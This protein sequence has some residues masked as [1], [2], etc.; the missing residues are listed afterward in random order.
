MIKINATDKTFS[1]AQFRENKG[2]VL[3]VINHHG[4]PTDLADSKGIFCFQ[5]YLLPK[6]N[7][8]FYTFAPILRTG[9]VR[10]IKSEV[11]LFGKKYEKVLAQDKAMYSHI[12]EDFG[13]RD[14]FVL[15]HKTIRD[16]LTG[17]H[18]I[19]VRHYALQ[20]CG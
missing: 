20:A 9:Y 16:W 15:L 2:R 3:G 12:S 14:N 4:I 19:Q 1:E 18:P 5:A 11:S 13:E 7:P 10:Y 8:F 17:A 6:A